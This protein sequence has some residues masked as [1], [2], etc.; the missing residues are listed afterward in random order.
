MTM[1]K[2]AKTNKVANLPESLANTMVA[3]KP[4]VYSLV[5]AEGCGEKCRIKKPDEAKKTRKR[6]KK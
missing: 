1:I 3:Q 4:D 6:S 5:D 2:N